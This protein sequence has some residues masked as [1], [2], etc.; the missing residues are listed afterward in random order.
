MILRTSRSILP[1]AFR[2]RPRATRTSPTATMHHFPAMPRR[3]ARVRRPHRRPSDL[4][5]MPSEDRSRE[6]VRPSTMGYGGSCRTRV[7]ATPSSTH[8]EMGSRIT[9][10]ARQSC[11]RQYNLG[12]A[13]Q[14]RCRKPTRCGGLP[15]HAANCRRAS[16]STRS[17]RPRTPKEEPKAEQ[18]Q[19][20]PRFAD[21]KTF[22]ADKFAEAKARLKAAAGKLQPASI[23]RWRSMA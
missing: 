15:P 21:N 6:P 3:H 2:S 13:Q 8:R 14:R 19:E 11:D 16:R 5:R 22:T 18:P 17:P 7:A 10:N 23:R 9:F 20:K 1:A 4:P 12:E